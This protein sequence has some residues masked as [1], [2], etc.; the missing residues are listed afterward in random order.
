[1]SKLSSRMVSCLRVLTEG[2]R[3]RSHLTATFTGWSVKALLKRGYIS[4]YEDNLFITT[5]GLAA[6]HLEEPDEQSATAGPRTE[7]SSAEVE[8]GGLAT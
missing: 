5:T 1:M 6:L 4:Q 2:P 8:G 7:T 3:P